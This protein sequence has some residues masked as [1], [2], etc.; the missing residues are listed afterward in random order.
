[1]A[2]RRNKREKKKVNEARRATARAK[3]MEAKCGTASVL[4]RHTRSGRHNPVYGNGATNHGYNMAR[5]PRCHYCRAPAVRDSGHLMNSGTNPMPLC[6]V[7]YKRVRGVL[8]AMTEEYS[9]RGND[10]IH[11]TGYH[12]TASVFLPDILDNG[13]VPRRV[14]G[15]VYYSPCASRAET[16]AKSWA[17]GMHAG[18][19]ASSSGGVVLSFSILED[20][21][22]KRVQRS[23]WVVSRSVAP[24]ELAVE[25]RIDLGDLRQDTAE[26]IGYLRNFIGVVDWQLDA[27]RDGNQF[28][29]MLRRARD[30]YD[31]LFNSVPITVLR[32]AIYVPWA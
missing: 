14:S 16:Y 28:A 2:G 9:R 7:C 10:D 13:L 25:N 31:R 29:K 8:S 4:I 19:A 6:S 32:D 11:S 20:D 27:Y 23:D 24:A 30:C 22:C 26:Y 18:G 15:Q 1:M 5:V 12:G 21:E 17:V 3:A